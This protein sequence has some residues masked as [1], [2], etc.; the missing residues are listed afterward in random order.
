[1]DNKHDRGKG[2][3]VN[4]PCPF[5][6]SFSVPL[7]WNYR[8]LM[9]I[10]SKKYKIVLF[11]F[12]VLLLM[13]MAH[14]LVFVGTRQLDF[15]SYDGQTIV[16]DYSFQFILFVGILFLMSKFHMGFRH[17]FY[18]PS[19]IVTLYALALLGATFILSNVF[20]SSFFEQLVGK[21]VLF[22]NFV[23]FSSENLTSYSINALIGSL[24]LAPVLEE[25]LYRHII[26]RK[27][28]FNTSY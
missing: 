1:M 12:V 4:A 13:Q 18:R 10:M 15:L 24:L 25:V 2:D 14:I 28:D 3:T 22:I 20:R 8:S 27:R 17:E 6:R 7:F 5:I 9:V 11:F 16:L 23:P 26:F 21:Q 19:L